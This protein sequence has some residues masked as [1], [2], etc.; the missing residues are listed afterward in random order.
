V[1]VCVCVCAC[2]CIAPLCECVRLS[3][4]T[5]TLR[6]NSHYCELTPTN[7]ISCP[8]TIPGGRDE[9]PHPGTHRYFIRIFYNTIHVR[10]YKCAYTAS[11]RGRTRGGFIP[12]IHC[13]RCLYCSLVRASRNNNNIL[14]GK[15]IKISHPPTPAAAVLLRCCTCL[16]ELYYYYHHLKCLL[17]SS[18]AGV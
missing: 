1:Y 17:L 9:I 6:A 13:R 5:R 12:K 16:S 7:A 3:D 14:R 2:T 8:E 18:E 10:S 4:S 15:K 11:V